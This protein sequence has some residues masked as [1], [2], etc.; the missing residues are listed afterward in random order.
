MGRHR[1]VQGNV[2][3]R[4]DSAALWVWFYDAAGERRR[5]ATRFVAGQ[6]AEARELLAEILRRVGEGL[7]PTPESAELSFAEWAERW[8]RDRRAAGK[9]EHLN[10][11]GHLEHHLVP[12][13]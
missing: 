11:R 8:A 13:L 12:L 2:Y 1:T 4:G 5:H 3:T 6:E 9:G 10:E 7:D